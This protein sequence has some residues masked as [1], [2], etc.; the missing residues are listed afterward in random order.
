MNITGLGPPDQW[1][2]RTLPTCLTFFAWI[3][4]Y[5]RIA[6]GSNPIR[7]PAS[8]WNDTLYRSLCRPAIFST[9]SQPPSHRHL[10]KSGFAPDDLCCK[11]WHYSLKNVLMSLPTLKHT[12]CNH[13]LSQICLTL[14]NLIISPKLNL[15]NFLTQAI[16]TI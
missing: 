6:R 10:E 13:T 8:Q 15:P 5:G 11:F 2:I 3:I 16:P 14:L 12:D 4:I 7:N 1:L 9:S